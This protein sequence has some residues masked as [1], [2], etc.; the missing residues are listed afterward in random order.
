MSRSGSTPGADVASGEVVPGVAI[1]FTYMPCTL[2]M[3]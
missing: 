3:F 1:I 2:H